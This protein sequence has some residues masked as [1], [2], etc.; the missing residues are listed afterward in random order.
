MSGRWPKKQIQEFYKRKTRKARLLEDAKI[1][2]DE[3]DTGNVTVDSCFS[4]ANDQLP[5][6]FSTVAPPRLRR[7]V[8]GAA[9]TS[10]AYESSW[11][12]AQQRRSTRPGHLASVQDGTELG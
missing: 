4:S 12:V 3:V 7:P 9:V 10:A 11:D 8:P 1:L 5:V 6:G 2:K